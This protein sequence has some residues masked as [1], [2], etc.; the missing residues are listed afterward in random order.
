MRGELEIDDFLRFYNDFVGLQKALRGEIELDSREGWLKIH[1][2]ADGLG[3][4]TFECTLMD[5][6]CFG[7]TLQ[8]RLETDQTFTRHTLEELDSIVQKISR[9]NLRRFNSI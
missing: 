7:N 4:F 1:I 8:C 3:H 6:P 5:S 9:A 2:V